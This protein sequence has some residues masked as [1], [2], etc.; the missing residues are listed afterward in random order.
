M[1]AFK[2]GFFIHAETN[3]QRGLH[4]FSSEISKDL[5][6]CHPSSVG[7]MRGTSLDIIIESWDLKLRWS[8]QEKGL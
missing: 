2:K 7:Y 6:A 3:Q 1:L 8:K 4:A 5:G